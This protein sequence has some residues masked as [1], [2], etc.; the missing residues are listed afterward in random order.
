MCLGDGSNY[1]CGQ[2]HYGRSG[3][4]LPASAASLPRGRR[5]IKAVVYLY[6]SMNGLCG[7]GSAKRRP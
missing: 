3:A 7:R 6:S 4:L 5:A 2:S 1:G